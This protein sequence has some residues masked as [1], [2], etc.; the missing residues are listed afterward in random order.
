MGLDCTAFR[1]LKKAAPGEG[2][3]EVDG[4]DV[5]AADGFAQLWL[6]DDFPGRADEFEHKAIYKP[7]EEFRW[8]AGSYTGYNHWRSQLAELA[9]FPADMY[10]RE[11]PND[12]AALPFFE[13]VWFA[14]NEGTLG[15]AVCACSPLT[16]RRSRRKPT[17]TRTNGFAGSMASGARR[18]R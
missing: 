18:A 13:L 2:I 17:R 11:S 3:G 15:T 7:T 4:D 10:F 16:S 5:Y 12:Y 6:N 14:D 8:R 1:Q 9:G